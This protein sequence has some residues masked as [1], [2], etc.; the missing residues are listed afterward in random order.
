MENMDII[1]LSRL[2][3]SNFEWDHRNYN[4]NE[5]INDT[6]N[7]IKSYENHRNRQPVI[8]ISLTRN[9]DPLNTT[10]QLL[11]NINTPLPRLQRQKSIHFNAEPV[12]LN[13]LTQPVSIKNQNIQLTPQQQVIFVRLI[14]S[15]NSQQT[16]NAPSPYNLQAAFTQAL[17][18]VVHTLI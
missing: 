9:L 5:A 4:N 16:N 6:T 14:K 2:M 8:S 11:P 18:T 1:V 7:K 13:R 3:D 17:S 10:L 15:Q 12:I